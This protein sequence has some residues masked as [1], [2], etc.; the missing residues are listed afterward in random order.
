MLPIAG[1][2]VNNNSGC[3]KRN[4]DKVWLSLTNNNRKPKCNQKKYDYCSKHLAE[5]SNISTKLHKTSEKLR[6][7]ISITKAV[8]NCSLM[9]N[10]QHSKLYVN[11]RFFIFHPSILPTFQSSNLPIF[12]FSIVAPIAISDFLANN[13]FIK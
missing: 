2:S 11:T 3:I 9:V 5:V 1:F 4:F 13:H 12:H 10:F 6:A 7:L 8:Q